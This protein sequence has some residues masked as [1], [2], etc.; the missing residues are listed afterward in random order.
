MQWSRIH[1]KS[2]VTKTT[3]KVTNRP[4]NDLTS[5]ALDGFDEA[6]HFFA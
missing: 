5:I 3:P 6:E 2:D 4:I 1:N